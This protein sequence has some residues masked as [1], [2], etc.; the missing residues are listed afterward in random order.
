MAQDGN[1]QGNSA[2][3]IDS[4]F[5]DHLLHAAPVVLFAT[6]QEGVI[7][8]SR[9]QALTGLGLGQDELVG[10]SVFDLYTNE[11]NIAQAAT[12]ALQ[13]ETVVADLAL[14]GTTHSTRF[15]PLNGPDS[16][17]QGIVGVATDITPQVEAQRAL[18]QLAHFDSLTG[19]P[20]RNGLHQYVQEAASAVPIIPFAV[21][22]IGLNRF[23]EVNQTFGYDTGDQ[24]IKEIANRF[25]TEP[26]ESAGD[27]C[28]RSAGDEFGVVVTGRDAR[29]LQ[30]R[31][32]QRV[33][34]ILREPI[35]VRDQPLAIEAS[36]GIAFFPG[37]GDDA[38]K[39]IRR[40]DTAMHRAKDK[41]SVHAI[42]D[43]IQDEPKIN[44]IQLVADLRRAIKA[45]EVELHY[46]PQIDIASGRIVA[47]EAL[48]RWSKLKDYD[49]HIGELL[50]VAE[51]S[52]VIYLLD[53][54]IMNQ[55]VETYA[56]MI[57]HG[58]RLPVAV[59]VSARTFQRPEFAQQVASLVDIWGMPPSDLCV[60][61][62]ET[63][64]VH[65]HGQLQLT[66]DNLRKAG[67]GVAID[68]FGTGNSSLVYLKDLGVTAIKIDLVFVIGLTDDK[69]AQTLTKSIIDMGN[70]LGVKVVAEGVENNEVLQLLKDMGCHEVQGFHLGRPMTLSDLVV[71]LNDQKS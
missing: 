44:N 2:A 39:L 26:Q 7:T 53:D 18:E 34:Q 64:M 30:N 68:D 25:T 29:T 23:R 13:G 57:R 67:I 3:G 63:A 10:T 45:G 14:N 5:V 40:A 33:D 6:D 11:P 58:Q 17:V 62:T 28:S 56:T 54:W 20:N 51:R 36:T 65:D 15:A 47:A 12:R 66:C 52:G 22:I 31:V 46:Q 61:I 60:E 41:G 24:A 37:H 9:G 70:N 4:E 8:L 69:I 19:L 59:N 43:R 71:R 49:I 48:F 1:K 42:Y 38:D 32:H 35:I 55:A 27:F 16:I 50:Q 21:A